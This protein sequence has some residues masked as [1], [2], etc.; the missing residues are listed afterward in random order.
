MLVCS[1]LLHPSTLLLCLAAAC[2]WWG[3][4]TQSLEV[5]V[6]QGLRL[7]EVEEELLQPEV[8]EELDQPMVEEACEGLLQLRVVDELCEEMEVHVPQRAARPE[9]EVN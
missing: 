1:L 8:D 9:P 5:E 6:R 7:L 2:A 4:A 3:P